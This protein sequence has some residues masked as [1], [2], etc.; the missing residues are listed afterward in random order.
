MEIPKICYIGDAEKFVL[1]SAGLPSLSFDENPFP[2][3]DINQYRLYEDQIV[4]LLNS[5]FL[6]LWVEKKEEEVDKKILPIEKN[7]DKILK[8]KSD[9]VKAREAFEKLPDTA[10]GKTKRAAENKVLKLEKELES[11]EK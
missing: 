5:G 9:L 6:S 10:H 8:I 11:L 7:V 3:T 2:F 1:K 4:Q